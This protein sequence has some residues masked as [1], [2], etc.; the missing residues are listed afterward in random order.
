MGVALSPMSPFLVLIQG[1][2]QI[3]SS[4]EGLLLT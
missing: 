3:G 2:S 4:P 1:L